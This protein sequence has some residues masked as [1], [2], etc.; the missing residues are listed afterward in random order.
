M[1]YRLHV[2]QGMTFYKK[3][4]VIVTLGVHVCV[5]YPGVLQILPSLTTQL[6]ATPIFVL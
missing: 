3:G 2:C 4:N 5:F 1:T 6:T